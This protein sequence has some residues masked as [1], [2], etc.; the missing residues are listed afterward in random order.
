MSSPRSRFVACVACLLVALFLLG[1]GTAAPLARAADGF[2]HASGGPLLADGFVQAPGGPSLTDGQGR[3]LI[4]HGVNMVAKCPSDSVPSSAFGSPCVPA[5]Q[6]DAPNYVLSPDAADP[7]RRFTAADARALHDLGFTVVRLGMIWAG[8]EP[9]PAGV[10]PDDPRYCSAHVVSAPFADS[11]V[12]S[13][14]ALDAYLAREDRIVRLLGAEGIRVILDMHQD[15][16]GVAFSHPAGPTPWEGEGAPRWATCSRPFPFS[17]PAKWQSSY[18]DPA[19]EAAF[20]H[21]FANDVSANLQGEFERVWRAVAA[22]YASD[23]N[24]AGFELFNEPAD[25]TVALGPEFDR[26]LACLYAGRQYAPSA[27]A[28]TTPPTQALPVGLM[29][30]IQS[31]DP[32]HLVFYEGPVLTDYLTPDTVGV[33]E[34][35]PFPRLVLSF[36]V[37]G[38]SGLAT[39]SFS[40]TDPSCAT[41]E[42]ADFNGFA[43]YRAATRTAQ[44]GGPAWLLSEFGAEP[45]APDIDRVAAMADARSLSWTEW[46]G[47]QLHDPTGSPDEGLLGQVSRV[48]DP[49]RAAVLARA[50]P[51]ATSGTPGPVT[52]DSVTG[53]FTYSYTPNRRVH[54]PTVIILPAWHYGQG[55]LASVSG[56]HVVSVPCATPLLLSDDPGAGKVSVTVTPAP[57]GCSS[58]A[59]ALATGT[60]SAPSRPAVCSP[61]QRL[62]FR[63]HGRVVGRPGVRRR[64]PGAPPPR[65]P[66]ARGL[67]ASS[68][69]RPVHGAH[70]RSPAQRR[71]P[72]DRADL[73]RVRQ[74]P[75]AAA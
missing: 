62:R 8:L 33:L 60:S 16:W 14:A 1:V 20:D 43:G 34:S 15:A 42:S 51:L 26:K 58:A 59:A 53:R 28:A 50:Y 54:A 74:D 69:R 66:A 9:G 65:A 57:R 52:F 23:T 38:A 36:H 56:A 75:S 41:T 27:C 25:A 17:S 44:P 73:S 37:Y 24:V 47:L 30:A 61:A 6:S 21:F 55:Y 22:H 35:L 39:S 11:G 63:L 7:G 19:V 13:Q 31:V 64:A 46:A 5:G 72:G 49:P 18:S 70:R 71:S 67:P 4:L 68:A 32:N 12:F 40:C 45:Y 29:P 3:A 10:K 2:V 48:P